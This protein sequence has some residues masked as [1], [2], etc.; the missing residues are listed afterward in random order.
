M[1]GLSEA[2]P[3]RTRSGASGAFYAVADEGYFLGAVGLVNSLR[4]VG[5]D[6]PIRLL[7]CGLRE[8][9]RALLEPEV[10]LVE[11][12]EDTPP[13][14]LKTIAPLAKPADVMVLIDVDMIATRRLGELAERAEDGEIAVIE[15][16][17]DR[18]CPEWGELLDLGPVRRRPY[19][20][21]GLVAAGRELGTEVLGLM[22]ELQDRVD[23]DLTFW[24]RDVRRYPFRFGDQDVLNGI[25]SSDRVPAERIATLGKR[26]AP[27]PPYRGLRIADEAT[28]RCSHHDGLEPM[29]VHQYIRKPWIESTYNG[30]YSRLLLRL[31]CG[32]DVAIR[33]PEAAVPRRLRRGPAATVERALINVR[34]APRWHLADQLWDSIPERLKNR[35]DERR[36]RGVYPAVNR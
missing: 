35:I 21:S 7:D 34:D 12:P 22:G 30:V 11:G 26:L 31:L 36:H 3:E 19:V 27:T 23:F 32:D 8:D 18:F 13:W 33:V 17:R 1:T 24:R 6:E 4:L 14:L 5:H 29:V 9:Q 2:A 28:L 20:S 15:N 10:E 16:F 25:L